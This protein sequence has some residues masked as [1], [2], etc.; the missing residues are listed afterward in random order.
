M[1]GNLR[2]C[3]HGKQMITK[4]DPWAEYEIRKSA[5]KRRNLSSRAYELEVQR[6]AKELGI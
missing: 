6:I 3:D 4:N 1:S 2:H 5:L